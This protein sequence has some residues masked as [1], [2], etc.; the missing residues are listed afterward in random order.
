[1]ET[2][3]ILTS[4]NMSMQDKNTELLKRSL[5]KNSQLHLIVENEVR[6]TP[7]G[8]ITFNIELKDGVAQV[9]TLN[10][11]KNRRRKYDGRRN[12]VE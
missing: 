9:D 10:I 7:F 11:V 1:M 6:Q 4:Q 3:W 2:L 12:T 5:L 8:Q